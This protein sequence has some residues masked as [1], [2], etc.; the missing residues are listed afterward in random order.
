MNDFAPY[1]CK[2]HIPIAF[3]FS[4]PGNDELIAGRPVAGATGE[5][6]EGAL[7]YLNSC[8]P[9]LFLST[10]RYEYR[11]ANAFSL[12]LAKNIGNGRTEASRSEILEEENVERFL[13][14]IRDCTHIILCGVKAGYLSAVLDRE[15]FSVSC[16]SHVGNKGLNGKFKLSNEWT[17]SPSFDRRQERIRIWAS[18]VL[19]GLG[20]ISS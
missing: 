4:A 8:V 7:T 1:F 11:I 19:Q 5:N 2:G 14:E 6:L 12:P 17:K 16:V 10:H 20:Q 9:T 15:I 3:V 13:N 18:K